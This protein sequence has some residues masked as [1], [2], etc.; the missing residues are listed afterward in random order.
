MP[1]YELMYI[2]ASAVS[3]DQQPEVAAQITKFVQDFGG[4]DI[5]DTQLGKKKLAYPIKKTR[6][7]FYGVVNFAMDTAKVNDL[8]AKI[9]T[10]NTIIRYILVNLEEYLE[11]MAKDREV[12]AQMNRN[13]PP[14]AV[15]ADQEAMAQGTGPVPASPPVPK[16]SPKPEAPVKLSSAELDQEIE[17]ALNEDIT[18]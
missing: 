13:R 3:D 6:N 18:K 5:Q 11:R 1:K 4:T 10:Q 16:P 8:D 14:E 15:A 9:R 7:G 2:L 17:K 12:Q